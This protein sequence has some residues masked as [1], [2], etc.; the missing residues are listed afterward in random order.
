MGPN[1]ATEWLMIEF[2][3][4][5]RSKV[6]NTSPEDCLSEKYDI[7]LEK[8]VNLSFKNHYQICIRPIDWSLKTDD[9]IF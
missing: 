3:P 5:S 4:L 8:S 2:C 9:V 6:C 7:L 1:E